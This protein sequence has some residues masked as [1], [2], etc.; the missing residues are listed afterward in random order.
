MWVIAGV[1]L[2]LVVLASVLGFHT[3][4]HTHIAASLLGFLAAVS[5][6]VLAVEGGASA[7]LWVLLAGDL[8]LSVG[9]G[10]LAWRGFS[11]RGRLS[12]ERRVLIRAG[13]EGVAVSDLD[14]EGIVRVQ[15]EEWSAAAINSPVRSGTVVQVVG[16]R[17][18]HLDVWG[19]DFPP[20]IHGVDAV[21][22][23]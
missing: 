16:R 11:D 19:E 13:A 9:L 7:L 20:A 10:F 2:G 3:G 21:S 5:L 8:T 12:T 23:G 1:L 17:G 4:P 18:V 15:G 14:P 22:P 6:V